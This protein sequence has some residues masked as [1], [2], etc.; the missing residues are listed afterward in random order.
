MFSVQR[1][2]QRQFTFVH[3]ACEQGLDAVAQDGPANAVDQFGVL[4][5]PDACRFWQARQLG[6]P[7]PV[8]MLRTDFGGQGTTGRCG[9]LY[10]I[11]AYSPRIHCTYSY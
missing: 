9:L 7:L 5:K 11:L 10:K 3:I 6:A 1:L 2:F 4:A 8:E